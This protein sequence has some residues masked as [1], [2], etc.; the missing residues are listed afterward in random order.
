[1]IVGTIQ[2]IYVAS[3]SHGRCNLKK[4]KKKRIAYSFVSHMGFIIIGIGS[5]S[6]MGLNGAILQNNLSWLYWRCTFF[7]VGTS[8]GRKRLVYLDEIGGMVV[9][10]PKIFMTLIQKVL[11]G[12][13]NVFLYNIYIYIYVYIYIYAIPCLFVFIKFCL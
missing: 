6:N 5:L 13:H 2:I 10:I 4:K 9:P 8:Y 12:L 3:A 1:M 7:L 11:D